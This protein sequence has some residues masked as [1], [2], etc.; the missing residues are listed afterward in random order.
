MAFQ[1][2]GNHH[3]KGSR[4]PPGQN[5]PKISPGVWWF[6]RYQSQGFHFGDLYGR[7]GGQ[8]KSSLELGNGGKFFQHHWIARVDGSDFD[9]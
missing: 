3:P 6:F 4:R 1:K 5:I 8:Q 2:Y 9:W 7:S